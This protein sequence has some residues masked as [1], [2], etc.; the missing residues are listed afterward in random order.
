MIDKTKAFSIFDQVLEASKAEQTEVILYSNQSALTRFANSEIHQNVEENNDTV[1][2]RAAL[3]KRLGVVSTNDLTRAGLKRAAREAADVAKNSPENPD[4]VGLTPPRPHPEFE[5]YADDAAAFSVSRRATQVARMVGI[6]KRKNLTCAGFVSQTVGAI[7]FGNSLG[8]KNYCRSTEVGGQVLAY[9]PTSSGIAE[10][11]SI[12]RASL[13]FAALAREAVQKA[14]KSADPIDLPPGDY[15]VVLDHYAVGD[16]M[17]YMGYV[18]FNAKSVQEQRS[19]LN[20]QIGAQ[21]F[22]PLVNIEDNAYSPDNA[23]LP[24]DFEGAPRQRVN[25]VENG[26]VKG[27]VYDS[28]TAAKDGCASTGHALPPPNTYGPMP[29]NLILKPGESERDALVASVERGIF[30]TRFHYTNLVDPKKLIVTGMTRDGTFL[31]EGGKIRK[32]VKNF[33]FTQNLVEAF[34]AVSMVSNK[35]VCS[36]EWMKAA[37]PAVKMDHFAFTSATLF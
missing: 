25:L 3:G 21:L 19:F 10:S 36:G 13:D 11:T 27:L 1:V 33:R 14:V 8:V 37:T 26:V 15:P 4:F 35:L 6:V 28:M 32:G 12:S 30:V 31:I 2:V 9:G 29:L 34:K 23:G 24:F 16:C 20:G 5:P 17:S 7:A 22:S 18:G